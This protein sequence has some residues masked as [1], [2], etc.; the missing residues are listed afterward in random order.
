MD[1][2]R[3]QALEVPEMFL[4]THVLDP[5]PSLEL[6]AVGPG[7]RPVPSHVAAAVAPPVDAAR[8]ASFRVPSVRPVLGPPDLRVLEG[9]LVLQA[10]LVGLVL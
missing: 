7:P 8:P 6:I 4:N 1:F 3:A 9:T 10:G 5:P 2:S